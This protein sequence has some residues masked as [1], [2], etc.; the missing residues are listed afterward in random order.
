MAKSKKILYG[1]TLGV[2]ILLII[3]TVLSKF[4]ADAIMPV[5]E[6]MN[7]VGMEMIIDGA[8]T[9]WHDTV[10]PA[11]A[12][13]TG[14]QNKKYVYVARQ[15]KGL[16]GPEHVVRLIEVRVAAVDSDDIY[17]ALGGWSVT[18]FDEVV[19]ESSRDLVSGEAVRVI[20]E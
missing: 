8:E 10:I 19:V 7:P 18:V 6:V 3:C 20:N 12:I 9:Q 16:F 13:I 14:E 4:I 17:A 15:Q 2:L 1:F 5:V 11:A